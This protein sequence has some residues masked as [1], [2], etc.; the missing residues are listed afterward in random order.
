MSGAGALVKQGTGKVTLTGN[1][2]FTGGTTVAAGT[3]ELGHA[4]AAGT[5]T[6]DMNGGHLELDT[7]GGP[8]FDNDVAA[9]QAFTLTV[10]QNATLPGTV[11]GAGAVT[12]AGAGELIVSADNSGFT[13]GI[14]VTGGELELTHQEAA[15]TG[16][17]NMNGGHLAFN[18][19]GDP[20]FDNDLLATQDFDLA[21]TQDAY[22]S[23][24]ISGDGAVTK[25]GDAT[26]TLTGNQTFT[27]GLFILGGMVIGGAD[28]NLGTGGGTMT[29]DG[30]TLQYNAGFTDTTRPVT[31]LGGGGTMDTAGHDAAWQGI[32][33]GIGQLTKTGNGVLTLGAANTFTGGLNVTGGTVQAGADTNLGAAGGGILLNGGTLQYSAD[34]ADTNRNLAVGAGGG[35][36]DTNG[37]NPTWQGTFSGA[38][39]LTRTGAGLWTVTGDSSGTYTG[40]LNNNAGLLL[41]NGATG[42]NVTNRALMMGSGTVGGDLLNAPGAVLNPGN[43]PGF[44]DVVGNFTNATGATLTIEIDPSLA[45]FPAT[46]GT[47]YDQVRVTGGATLQVNNII[48]VDSLAKGYVA[49]GDTFTAITT[50]TGVVDNGTILT[51]DLPFHF[52]TGAIVGNTYQLTANRYSYTLGAGPGNPTQVAL[53]LDALAAATRQADDARAETLLAELDSLGFGRAFASALEYLSPEPYDVLDRVHRRTTDAF[54]DV[55]RRYM[56]SVRGGGP[57]LTAALMPAPADNEFEFPPATD[58]AA[59]APE[60]TA[61]A[62]AEGGDDAPDLMPL[63]RGRR[64]IGG[65]AFPFGLRLEE[66]DDGDRTGYRACMTGVQ[67]GVDRQVTES[68]L[69][70]GLFQYGDT[71]VNYQGLGGS[72]SIDSYR[73]G[74]YAGHRPAPGWYLDGMVSYGFHQHEADRPIRVGTLFYTAESDWDGHDV[75]AQAETG[76]DLVRVGDLA[77]TPFLSVAYRCYHQESHEEH[78]AGAA[79]LALDSQTTHGLPMLLGMRFAKTIAGPLPATAEVAAGWRH[80]FLANDSDDLAARF[81]DAPTGFAIRRGDREE[82]ALNLDVS[83]GVDL[84]EGKHLSAHY[85]TDW[86]GA[87]RSHE[88]GIALKILW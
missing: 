16:T 57:S 44:I 71:D 77:V 35:T 70:G 61:Q 23:G 49:Q 34:F 59:P 1:S 36:V 28:G 19:A 5:G 12:K 22:F 58:P 78:G 8:D 40:L 56:A 29:F 63:P 79:S 27:G 6:L 42:G 9:T 25:K 80:D 39:T 53:G 37:Q 69:I 38:G 85:A 74:A 41:F 2:S 11:S 43:S 87:S 88:F 47:H 72:A 45:A 50:G 86:A 24:E 54:V 31:L 51:D 13:G 14:E 84:G 81:I 62:E 17:L 60:P 4:N 68:L 66:E 33:G 83:L 26:L 30:G 52:F 15:G 55:H 48:D 67:I 46:P 76:Y 73:V 20:D 3:L 65:Y 75:T 10:S 7:A 18:A 64:G 82:D 32:I 21:V